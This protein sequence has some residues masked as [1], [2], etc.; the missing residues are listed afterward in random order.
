[1]ANENKGAEN[2]HETKNEGGKAFFKVLQSIGYNGGQYYPAR[3]VGD[4]TIPADIVEMDM[5]AA[6]AFGKD[7]V[8]K[9]NKKDEE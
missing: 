9:V 2:A 5:D 7:Y 8:Q 3:K 6:K 1:M 4:K